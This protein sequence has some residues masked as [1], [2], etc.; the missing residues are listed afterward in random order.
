VDHGP[1]SV[2]VILSACQIP[3]RHGKGGCHGAV[4][5]LRLCTGALEC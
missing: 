2:V 3:G 5:P 1:G 4:T